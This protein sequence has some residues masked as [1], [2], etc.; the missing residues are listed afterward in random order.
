VDEAARNGDAV[1]REILLSA[2]QQLV[3]LSV[4]VRAQLFDPGAP[5]RISYIGGVFSSE[6]LLARYR[7][8]MEMEDGNRV[9]APVHG[10]AAGA[11]IE[12][13]RAAGLNISLKE[14]PDEK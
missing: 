7:M 10:P 5:C 6:I 9:A 13:Y 11:L 14:A 1:A 8:L 12:A 4:S 3:T 2:A